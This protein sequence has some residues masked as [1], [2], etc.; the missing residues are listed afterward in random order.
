[1]GDRFKVI[2]IEQR[3]NQAI[4]S[5]PTNCWLLKKISIVHLTVVFVFCGGFFR[6]LSFS[7]SFW[8]CQSELAK[9]DKEREKESRVPEERNNVAFCAS[10]LGEL[11]GCC[12][13][14]FCSI[15]F[16][17][18][19][20]H[21]KTSTVYTKSL[22]ITFDIIYLSWAPHRSL[23]DGNQIDL[24]K[25]TKATAEED[26]ERRKQNATDKRFQSEIH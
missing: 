1:M 7:L 5:Q 8:P 9:V 23:L 19:M 16:L 26:P 15:F 25:R 13:R 6:S 14:L 12:V 2:E 11:N 24:R 4:A 10:N 18:E 20:I 21:S 17:L 3:K 22:F